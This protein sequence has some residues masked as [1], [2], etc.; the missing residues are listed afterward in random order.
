MIVVVIWDS[1][2]CLYKIELAQTQKWQNLTL[3][4]TLFFRPKVTSAQNDQ[5][6]E[7]VLFHDNLANLIC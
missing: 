4:P 6:L 3:M 1:G 2:D 5:R 7:N